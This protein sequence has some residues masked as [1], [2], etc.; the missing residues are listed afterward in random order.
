M[1]NQNRRWDQYEQA[2]KCD[3]SHESNY[4]FDKNLI[5]EEE[6]IK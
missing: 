2:N 6:K 1:R 3:R 4:Y 5:K